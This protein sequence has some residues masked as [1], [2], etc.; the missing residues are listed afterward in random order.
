MNCFAHQDATAV[1][2]CK[3]CGRAVCAKC[4]HDLDFAVVCSDRCKS[5]ASELHEMNARAKRIYGLGNAKPQFPLG[6]VI[7]FLLAVPFIY[8]LVTSYLRQ[9]VVEWFALIFVFAC[10]FIGAATYRRAKAL[11]VNC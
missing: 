8:L 5:E 7:W 3:G 1:A 9:G 10:L 2:V 11:Q 6:A 4:A